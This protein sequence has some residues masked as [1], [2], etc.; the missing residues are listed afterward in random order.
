MTIRQLIVSAWRDG[1]TGS[2]DCKTDYQNK[3]DFE[4]FLDDFEEE[5]VNIESLIEIK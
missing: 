1:R 5:I 2:H 3:I 4:N